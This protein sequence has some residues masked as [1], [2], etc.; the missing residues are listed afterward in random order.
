MK[1]FLKD[2][3]TIKNVQIC[4]KRF[5][6]LE[7]PNISL[8]L[9]YKGLETFTE[10]MYSL[11]ERLLKFSLANKMMTHNIILATHL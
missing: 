7:M 10:M 3:R 5:R 6:I 1:I 9:E 2:F 8:R 4:L 11:L